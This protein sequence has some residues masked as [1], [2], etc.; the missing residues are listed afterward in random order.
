MI[1]S[2]SPKVVSG[3]KRAKRVTATTLSKRENLEILYSEIAKLPF[4]YKA[5]AGNKFILIE[6]S[7]LDKMREA[8]WTWLTTDRTISYRKNWTPWYG[9]RE[10][11]QNSLDET[12]DVKIVYDDILDATFV[13]DNGNGFKTKHLLL[14]E[15]KGLT[16]EEQHLVRG[17]F[18][19]GM[20]L[21]A[22][23]FFRAGCKIF[24]RTVGLDITFAMGPFDEHYVHYTFKRPNTNTKGT[25]ICISNFDGSDLVSNFAPFIDKD[26]VLLSVSKGPEKYDNQKVRA[27]YDLPGQMYVR[28]IFVNNVNVS[29]YESAY[30]GYNFW[31]NNPVTALDPDRSYIKDTAYLR[32]EFSYILGCEDVEFLKKYFSVIS[33]PDANKKISEPRW[34]FEHRTIRGEFLDLSKP[35]ATAIFKA[36]ES[37]F[38]SKDFTWSTNYAEAKALEHLHIVDLTNKIPNLLNPLLRY[39]LVKK[40]SDW[41]ALRDL[42]KT[43]AITPEMASTSFGAETGNALRD[44]I[45]IFNKITEANCGPSYSVDFFWALE[46]SPEIERVGGFYTHAKKRISISILQL[47]SISDP[48]KTFIHE[49]AHALSWGADDLTEDF[50]NQL[51]AAGYAVLNYFAK[52]MDDHAKLLA[53]LTHLTT[54]RWSGMKINFQKESS[55]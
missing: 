39:D 11:V 23:P 50:E 35:Q 32:N 33:Q 29:G 19:E 14:G 21:A 1:P 4:I 12:K 2:E 17:C 25:Q 9:L 44:V 42:S 40:A 54:K 27:V 30:F 24:I 22:L 18:G 31:L 13:L 7:D 43:I 5:H 3:K 36:L 51:P 53:N 55:E 52:N 26:K 15:Y 47:Y 45:G 49:L 48:I 10:F 34:S 28:D 6:A 37:V 8:G 46:S 20:K 16:E 41:I 38:G